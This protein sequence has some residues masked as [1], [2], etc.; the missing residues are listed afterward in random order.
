MR[1]QWAAT[2]LYYDL[3]RSPETASGAKLAAIRRRNE[4]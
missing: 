2:G 1:F 4:R 3:A